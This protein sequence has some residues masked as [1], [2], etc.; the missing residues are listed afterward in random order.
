[1]EFYK[2]SFMIMMVVLIL[3]LTVM[4]VTL[5]YSNDDVAFPPKLGNCPD[6][7][8]EKADGTCEDVKGLSNGRTFHG[9]QCALP[10]FSGDAFK[11]PGLGPL[12]GICKKKR[13][14]KKCEVPWD[15]ITNNSD[16]CYKINE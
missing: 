16:V 11:A 5:H 10:D 6:F 7:Y 15:G 4:G 1:M 13:W 3:I 12:S 2:T 8:V 14:A 9:Q